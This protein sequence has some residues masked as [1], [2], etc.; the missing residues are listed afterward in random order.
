MRHA[1]GKA[2]SFAASHPDHLIIGSDQVVVCNDRILGKP[3]TPERAVEQLALMGGRTSR[4]I[5]A[6]HIT[7]PV[8]GRSEEFWDEH[9]LS[10]R[11]LPR[12]RLARY[13]AADNPLWCAGSFKLEQRGIALFERIEGGDYTGIIGLP[14]MGTAAA[15]E[16]F[17]WEVP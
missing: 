4:L 7:H 14:L 1:R 10:V 15:L 12:E 8:S 17:G 5:T 2:A 9:R 13:V 3:G 6:V 11:Q 16:R